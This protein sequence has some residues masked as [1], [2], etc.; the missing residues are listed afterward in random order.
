MSAGRMSPV[1]I[2]GTGVESVRETM[3]RTNHAAETGYKALMARTPHYR[4]NMLN[5]GKAR[6]FYFRAVADHA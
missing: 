1:I 6:K 5:N 2:T 4:K 3:M